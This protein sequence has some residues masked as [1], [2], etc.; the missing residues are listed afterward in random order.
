MS[1][2]CCDMDGMGN[3]GRFPNQGRTDKQLEDSYKITF[4]SGIIFVVTV[5][6]SVI[7]S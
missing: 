6:L 7:F 1:K 3:Q 5:L 2:K 4:I